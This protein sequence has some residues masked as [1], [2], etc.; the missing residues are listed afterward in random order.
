M[1]VELALKSPRLTFLIPNIKTISKFQ[2]TFSRRN[3]NFQ[4]EL[5]S[6]RTTAKLFPGP[7][8]KFHRRQ[9]RRRRRRR[10]CWCRR[11][12]SWLFSI[13]RSDYPVD[14]LSISKD[15]SPIIPPTRDNQDLRREN[16][17]LH[18]HTHTDTHTH[19]HRRV[20]T[21]THKGNARTHTQT[22]IWAEQ[23][24]S[25][26]FRVIPWITGLILK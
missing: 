12:Y 17:P 6:G 13:S 3:N 5:F 15:F 25:H 10:R 11:C 21:S 26:L 8:Q 4:N 14:S 1:A 2:L 7:P 24:R 18:T 23:Q 19:M 20:R 22:H 9:R 16:I